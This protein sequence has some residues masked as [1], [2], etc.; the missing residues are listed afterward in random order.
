MLVM[1]GDYLTAT[2]NGSG[3]IVYTGNPSQVVKNVKGSG[4]IRRL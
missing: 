4:R 1:A 3:D 2:V